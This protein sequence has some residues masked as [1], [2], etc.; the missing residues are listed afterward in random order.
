MGSALVRQFWDCSFD[1]NGNMLCSS[2]GANLQH[3][4]LVTFWVG[5]AFYSS[6]YLFPKT[7]IREFDLSLFREN[8]R[9]FYRR[10][11]AALIGYGMFLAVGYAVFT[12]VIPGNPLPFSGDWV[13][14]AGL[15]A[16]GLMSLLRSRK[17]TSRPT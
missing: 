15:I 10:L 11:G 12:F 7:T 5:A 6:S 16:F 3:I 9:S 2:S 4:T 1:I 13:L 8:K 17:I 14:G